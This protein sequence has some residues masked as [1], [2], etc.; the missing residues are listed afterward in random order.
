VSMRSWPGVISGIGSVDGR[1][2]VEPRVE[3]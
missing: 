1:S 2:G 3:E